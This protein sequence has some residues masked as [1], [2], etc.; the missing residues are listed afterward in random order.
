M[1]VVF[2]LRAAL[3]IVLGAFSLWVSFLNW[4]V[5]IKRFFIPDQ[6][7]WTP[8]LA[9]LVGVAA[10]F[11]QPAWDLG[12]WVCLPLLVD[13]G[14]A[15]GLILTLVGFASLM[16]NVPAPGQ[17]TVP[18]GSSRL[19][20]TWVAKHMWCQ[21]TLVQQGEEQALGAECLDVVLRNLAIGLGGARGRGPSL[22]FE[23]RPVVG[24]LT[25]SETHSTTHFIDGLGGRTLLI[26]DRDAQERARITLSENERRA[27]LARVRVLALTC[28][29]RR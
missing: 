25:L 11:L 15:P 8:L 1:S 28:P 29:R 12:G 16:V 4:T 6:P 17:A 14:C 7:S 26:Q 13:G 27:A 23:G 21:V 19:Q 22:H 24:S 5:L 3:A 10:L 20:L 18:L 2:V 9:G